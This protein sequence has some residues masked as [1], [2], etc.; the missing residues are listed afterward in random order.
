[1]KAVL[2]AV[3]FLGLTAAAGAQAARADLA[4]ILHNPVVWGKD[5]RDI[6]ANIQGWNGIGEQ[7][8]A[9]FPTRVEGTQPFRFV[10]D[11]KRSADRWLEV[12]RAPKP[13]LTPRFMDIL[14]DAARKSSEMKAEA[15]KAPDGETNRVAW[16][17]PVKTQLL[18]PGLT[19]TQVREQFGR[20]ERT[21]SETI[22]TDDD[23]RPIIL[24]KYHYAGD[25]AVFAVSD[26]SPRPGSIDRVILNV[27]KARDTVFKPEAR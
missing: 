24:K 2:C 10:A 22:Q 14:S 3:V 19:V 16:T 1:M 21:S 15:V 17:T 20:E 9:I 13:A 4:S 26:F 25:A 7:R 27:P 23:R 18:A 6:L 5:F 12:M 8:I 11:A